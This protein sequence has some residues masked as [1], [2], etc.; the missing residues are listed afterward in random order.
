MMAWASAMFL[1]VSG[2]YPVSEVI[3]SGGMPHSPAGLGSMAPPTSAKPSIRIELKGFRSIASDIALR[4]SGLSNGGLTRL[5]IRL[6]CVPVG[7]I[8]QTAFGARA[9]MSFN[10]G[11]LTSDGKVMSYSPVANASIRVERLSIIR[12]VISSRYG[13][14][15]FQYSA[16]RVSLIEVPR[17]NSTNLNGPVPTGLVRITA[18]GTWQ[19]YTGE[20]ALASSTGR[21]GCGSL[22]SNVA[23][24]SPLMLTS[25]SFEYQTF[26]GLRWKSDVSPLP[27]SIRQVHCTSFDVN[28]LPSCQLTPCRSL[29]VS[30]VLVESHDQLSARSGITVSRLS[31]TLAGSNTTRLLKTAINGVTEA[32]VDSSSSEV[33]GGL[34]L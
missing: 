22:S 30:L 3:I 34:S 27:I 24:K 28:G 18:C 23:S 26:R 14:S 12:K 31:C 17:L 20:N 4:M 2:P 15:F 13:R 8:S 16:L 25:C 11:T 10:R 5:T 32:M 29:K 9:L 1:A 33:E 7:I 6:I 19:G 21:L